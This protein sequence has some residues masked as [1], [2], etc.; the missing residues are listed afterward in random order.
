MATFVELSTKAKMPI[1]GLGTWKVSAILGHLLPLRGRGLGIFLCLHST[2][3]GFGTLMSFHLG[4][5]WVGKFQDKPFPEMTIV[6]MAG[7]RFKLVLYF[8]E[9]TI[10]RAFTPLESFYLGVRGTYE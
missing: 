8:R 9:R 10:F 5:L 2:C 4:L 1:V 7:I 3:L 6:F